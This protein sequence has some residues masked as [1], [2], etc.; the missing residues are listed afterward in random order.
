[1][2]AH[3]NR[4]CFYPSCLFA[5]TISALSMMACGGSEKPSQGGF[6]PGGGSS[7]GGGA[8]DSGGG[9]TFDSGGG[10]GE[11]GGNHDTG[12]GDSG[13]GGG[14][15]PDLQCN[16]AL[17]KG[18]AARPM[19]FPIPAARCGDNFYNIAGR[20]E[21]VTHH[22]Q[23]WNADGLPD[24]VI[25]KDD[26]DKSM[27][28]SHWD[29]YDNLDSGFAL[30]PR[31]FKIPP[32]R[33]NTSFDLHYSGG[34]KHVLLDMNN[35]RFADIVVHR[36]DCDPQ[37]GQ[38]FWDI[39]N[40]SRDG[41]GP[42]PRKYK[43]PPAR[44]N[45]R[46]DR[47]AN[48]G[49]LDYGLFDLTADGIPDLVVHGDE[50]DANLGV[51]HWDVYTGG[52]DGFAMVPARYSLP[53][54]RC[55]GKWDRLANSGNLN[56]VL[57]NLNNDRRPDLVVTAENCSIEVGD[58]HWD[59][60]NGGAAGFTVTPRRFT[61]PPARCSTKFNRIVNPSSVLRHHLNTIN[62][63]L[64]PEL[65]VVSD[66]CDSEVGVSRWDIYEGSES[67]FQARPRPFRLPAGRCNKNFD[68]FGGSSNLIWSA[69]HL[70]GE[71]H[72]EFVISRD[73]CEIDVGVRQWDVYRME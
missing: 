43:I 45:T 3:M 9:G 40:G 52:P 65:V 21:G 55:G 69:L 17:G 64:I 39:Y 15:G 2:D 20:G 31:T 61:I 11:G 32:A 14:G 58:T 19:N 54:V 30:R 29:V 73:V 50:C 68:N 10:N 53:P 41:I 60:Y 25:S 4:S 27:V 16:P 8:P 38:D 71:T 26:C 12:G 7:G 42:V 5:L 6:V 66:E 70:N 56:Y 67:G 18:M 48:T 35:D 37:V 63:D 72:F 22:L 28:N 57:L 49:E 46:F 1:M 13:G 62:C 24:L 23:D 47:I 36:E 33:C 59:V 51:T 34:A 44:C